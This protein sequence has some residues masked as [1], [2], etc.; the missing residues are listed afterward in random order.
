MIHLLLAIIYLSFI[1]L[2]LPDALLG[3]AWPTMY[4]QLDVPVS[5]AGIISMI[6]A[7]STIL[8]S[9]SSDRLVR[10]LGTAKVTALSVALTAL[11][12]FGFSVSSSFWM[13]CLFAIPYGLGAGSVDAALNNFV[14]LHYKAR[15]MSWLHCFWGIGATLGP[16][17]MGA[18]LTGG[19]GWNQG[20]R[21]VSWIQIALTAALIFSLPLWKQKSAET[22][23][24]QQ[25]APPLKLPQMLALRGAKPTL[26]AFFCYCSLE[27]ATGLWGSSYMVLARGF[28]AEEAASQIALFYLGITGGRFL[29]GFLTM[30]LNSRVMVRL[31]QVLMFAGVIVVFIPGPASLLCAGFVLIGF[32]CAP[33]FPGLLH[34]TPE[35]FGAG[36]S[37]SMMGF[38]MACAYTGGIVAP[39]LVGLLTEKIHISLFPIAL[40]VFT[41]LMFIM[42]ELCNRRTNNQKV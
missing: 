37:Q 5:Y 26:L 20:Y 1:S 19:L 21:T 8:S 29:S 14:A 16:Y 40:L 30:K 39:P 27:A 42:T 28:S 34:Q 15:H 10:R 35:K 9:L 41:A 25:A 23:V 11:A 4:P 18:C 33:V 31:G 3:S 22:E 2:G 32:G 36:A 13:L 7:G 38:Q 12:L 6:I 17:I 24:A